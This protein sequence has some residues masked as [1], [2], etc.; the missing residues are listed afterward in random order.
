MHKIQAWHCDYC[1]KVLV[2]KENMEKHEKNCL[3][4]P[5]NRTCV[6]CWNFTRKNYIS[7][8]DGVNY[9]TTPAWR[10]GYLSPDP[11]NPKNRYGLK[12]NCEYW[13]AK[14]PGETGL[15]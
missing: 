2:H 4:N 12:K 3:K 8:A 7:L 11:N 10:E 15:E 6:T 14:Y 13:K 5:A 1:R 9:E